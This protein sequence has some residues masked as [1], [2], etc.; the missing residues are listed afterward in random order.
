M[1]T[2][3]V[4]GTGRASSAPDVITVFMTVTAGDMDYSLTME[5]AAERLDALRIALHGVGFEKEDLKTASFN[6]NTEFSHEHTPDGR[7]ERRFKGYTCTHRLTLKFDLDMDRL[8]AV[9]AAIS[10]CSC[11]PEFSLS[12]GVRDEDGFKAEMLRSAAANARASA[13]ILA[14]ASGVTL[15]ELVSVN[16]SWGSISIESNTEFVM[17]KA[18]APMAD[19]ALDFTP[20][21]ITKTDSATFVWEIV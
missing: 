7:Y 15:G 5:Q 2:I 8:S 1:K 12:F 6:V 9:I 4:T 14:A 10:G 16:Y 17:M 11:M 18:A 13:E 21:D 3:T 19:G 20:E